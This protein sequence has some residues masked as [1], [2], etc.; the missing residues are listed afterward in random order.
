MAT[1]IKEPK[2]IAISG[3]SNSGKTTFIENLIPHLKEKGYSVGVVKHTHHDVTMDQEGK[4]SWR[5]QQAGAEMVLLASP[6]ALSVVKKTEH[7]LTL[8]EIGERCRGLDL[9]IAEGY[10]NA[11]I[12]KIE[13]FRKAASLEPVCSDDPNL[14][15]MITDAEIGIHVPVFGLEAYREVAAFIESTLLS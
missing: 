8:D 2:I 10:K 6:N 14:I 13:I 1:K 9:L 5:H 12:T 7:Q 4:D 3:V 11:D 15:G